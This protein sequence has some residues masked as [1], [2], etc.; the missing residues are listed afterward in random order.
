MSNEDAF[1]KIVELAIK[2]KNCNPE[3]AEVINGY[4]ILKEDLESFNEAYQIVDNALHE[5]QEES[6]E[7]K[8]DPVAPAETQEESF[9]IKLDPIAPT[10]TQPE[11][12]TPMTD[13]TPVEEPEQSD[14]QEDE[15]ILT[16]NSLIDNMSV[17]PAPVEVTGWK[18]IG[19]R[20]KEKLNS[21]EFK[22]L[23]KKA[24]ATIAAVGIGIA[25]FAAGFGF[26]K[27][28]QKVQ[29]ST[30]PGYSVSTVDTDIDQPE[31]VDNQE[32]E[33]EN[34]RDQ[35]A[36]P[37]VGDI[38]IGDSIQGYDTSV[39]YVTARDAVD[40]TNGVTLNHQY[41]NVDNGSHVDEFVVQNAD[42][43]YTRSKA[44]GLTLS[45]F[46]QQQGVDESQV[47]ANITDQKGNPQA[48]IS[49]MELVQSDETLQ[50]VM[51]NEARGR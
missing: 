41:I 16:P 3:D 46:A 24:A 48:W 27:N 33:A 49:G 5:T 21:P 26:G 31:I 23:L 11:P 1:R 45:E 38:T 12:T 37:Q 43:S 8:L 34:R 18:G 39:G 36:S 47:A 9:E 4:T 7:I 19:A 17:D 40:Q 22:K 25:V 6:F 15:P 20:L 30:D 42:G 29:A 35:P 51:A 10:E 14:K 13:E 50:E 2:A 44:T 28:T 32:T